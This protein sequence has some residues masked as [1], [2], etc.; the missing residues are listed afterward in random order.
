M[1]SE[2]EYAVET[3][4]FSSFNFLIIRKDYFGYI[5][6]NAQIPLHALYTSIVR[7]HSLARS[8]RSCAP[9]CVH[10]RSLSSL[11]TNAATFTAQ[12]NCIVFHSLSPPALTATATCH[13]LCIRCKLRI[14]VDVGRIDNL[15]DRMDGVSCSRSVG[16]AHWM[17]VRGNRADRRAE[18]SP[19]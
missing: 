3:T 19:V 16:D 17:C 18:E 6:P 10:S 12:A 1:Q 14:K 11:M 4:K 5:L 2:V 9:S 7:L 15:L 13:V 8:L